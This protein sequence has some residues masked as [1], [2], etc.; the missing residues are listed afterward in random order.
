MKFITS[1][2][3][4]VSVIALSACGMGETYPSFEGAAYRIE[5]TTTVPNGGPDVLTV[6]Y[7][8]GPKMR[9][10][11]VLPQQGQVAIVFD[12]STNAAFVLKS[13]PPAPIPAPVPVSPAPTTSPEPSEMT[14]IAPAQAPDAQIVPPPA[15]APAGVAVRLADTDAPRPLEAP[16][17]ALGADGAQRVGDCSVAGEDG[18]EWR[19]RDAAQGAERIACITDD[20]IVLSV[21]EG[22]RVIFQA[23]SLQRGPQDPSLFGVPA[24]YQL[25]DPQ[26]VADQVGDSMEQLDSVTGAPGVNAP[27]PGATPR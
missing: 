8:D 6:M 22:D 20:G 16:W 7:R 5:G 12:E 10:E 11:T 27:L 3:A 19:P 26:A 24:G 15:P 23:T 14:E 2:A 18:D 17:A 4:T 9:V 13:A 21:R 1:I 25:I